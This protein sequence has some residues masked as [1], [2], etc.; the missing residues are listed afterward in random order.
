[1]GCRTPR[2]TSQTGSSLRV[3]SL[4]RDGHGVGLARCHEPRSSMY[5]SHKSC[6]VH[7]SG[8]IL[9]FLWRWARAWSFI[10][11]VTIAIRERSPLSLQT[12]CFR[13]KRA[14]SRSGG[15]CLSPTTR[16]RDSDPVVWRT[17]SVFPQVGSTPK[18][19]DICSR[20]QATFTFLSIIPF[21]FKRFLANLSSPPAIFSNNTT[22]HNR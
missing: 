4:G 9:F 11:V 22:S 19:P 7:S 21:S 18:T 6:G 5:S 15:S 14:P 8:L 16:H 12:N 3:I 10:R 17:Q 1:M 20:K 13:K 2:R